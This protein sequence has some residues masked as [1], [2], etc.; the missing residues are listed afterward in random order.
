MLIVLMALLGAILAC[1]PRAEPPA[2]A[3]P[4][5]VATGAPALVVAE[6]GVPLPAPATVLPAG[7]LERSGDMAAL[8]AEVSPERLYDTVTALSAINSRHV[9]STTIR[10]AAETIHGE[11]EAAGGRL[12]V[13]YDDFPL[14]WEEVYSTQVNV[15]ATLPGSD[16]TAGMIVIGAHYDSRT[17]DLN[18][19]NA[20]AP[21]AN[22]NGSGT[23]VVIELARVLA[24]ETP[25]STIVFAAF[26]AEEVGK[27]G[28]THYVQE[29]QARGDRIRAMIALDIVG[30]A[31][32]PAGE[33]SIRVFS[34][35]PPDSAS[36]QLART[37]ALIG[38]RDVPGFDVLVQPAID[39]PYRYSD[40]VPFSEAGIPAARLIETLEDTNRQHSPL[41]RPEHLSAFYLRDATQLTLAS[42][43]N[44]AWGPDTPAL[45]TVT[46]ER[47]DLLT[48]NAVPGAA[49][50]LVAYRR[51]EEPGLVRTVIVQGPS[52]VLL[53]DLLAQGA[54][55]V[56]VAAIG[57]GGA[58]SLLSPEV[59]VASVPPRG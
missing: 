44:L 41:D 45:P 33:G 6:T 25:R 37:I 7:S 3:P 55:A 40:H 57:P 58:I 27:V 48:W 26:S 24:D 38:A 32:G 1:G 14:V 17:Y 23:A 59:L 2:A 47:P 13:E 21:G 50:Y 4:V 52:A 54:A 34:A 9:H 19:P 11:F 30:N 43:A 39:R 31:V 49:G 56:S 22:D 29:A 18:D 51:P 8:L 16:P 36:R 46:V 12:I 35:D 42:A 15:I 20:P 53:P 10:S 28:S 5:I